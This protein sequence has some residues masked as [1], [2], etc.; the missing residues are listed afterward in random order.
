MITS[1][2]AGRALLGSVVFLFLLFVCPF[3]VSAQQ[4]TRNDDEVIKLE[5]E[6][7]S[8]PVTVRDRKSGNLV[9]SLQQKDFKIYEDGVEQQISYFSAERVPVN[10]VLLIDTSSSVQSEIDNIKES[11]WDFINQMG[12]KDKFSIITFTDTVDLV[13]DWTSDKAK[14]RKALGNLTMGKFTAFN[15][16]LYL[17]ATEQ[18]KD[19]KGRKALIVLSDGVDNRA[20]TMT[21]D[22]AYDAVMRSEANIYI[23]S[24]TAI[25]RH[26]FNPDTAGYR[27]PDET[28][29]FLQKTRSI[30]VSYSRSCRF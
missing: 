21:T 7:V 4:S 3:L 22:Q 6:E 10:I 14:A 5:A 8:I 9:A 20:S 15:D 1:P 12:D 13:L 17:A 18:L 24:K 26:R 16:A 11:A 30:T 19:I 25:L 27:K 29:S 28:F 2:P 23:V